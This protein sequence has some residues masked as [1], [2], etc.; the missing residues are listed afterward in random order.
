M[1]ADGL[2][3]PPRGTQHPD[4]PEGPD[5]DFPDADPEGLESETTLEVEPEA[6]QLDQALSG[7]P[8]RDL[9]DEQLSAMSEQQFDDWLKSLP[10]AQRKAGYLRQAKFTKEM[11]RLRERERHTVAQQFAEAMTGQRTPSGEAPPTSQYGPVPYPY[12][13]P[14]QAG[15]QAGYDPETEALLAGMAPEERR[16]LEAQIGRIVDDRVNRAVQRAVEPVLS[17]QDTL[18][19]DQVRRQLE[20]NFNQLG[21]LYPSILSDETA[22]KQLYQEM[23]STLEE[24]GLPTRDAVGTYRR[25]FYEEAVRQDREREQAKLKARGQGQQQK[26]PKPPST[27]PRGAAGEQKLRVPVNKEERVASMAQ[28]LERHERR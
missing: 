15:P 25:L 17:R 28:F 12:P 23:M 8:P 9:T 20:T 2:D 16:A 4:T 19:R 7:Q 18:L 6:G 5:G 21:E 1:A 22:Q 10:A 27:S 3:T 24:D 26:Q 11:Q 13:P 14:Q